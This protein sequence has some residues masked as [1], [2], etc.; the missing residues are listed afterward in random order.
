MRSGGGLQ[1]AKC[2]SHGYKHQY[3]TSMTTTMVT[4]PRMGARSH[5]CAQ[6]LR[7]ITHEHLTHANT[8]TRTH[9]TCEHMHTN[10]CAYPPTPPPPPP[11]TSPRQNVRCHL[12]PIMQEVRT[13]PGPTTTQ[14]SIITSDEKPVSTFPTVLMTALSPTCTCAPILTAFLS[15]VDAQTWYTQQKHDEKCGW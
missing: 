11:P 1:K 10:T 4:N 15:P 12:L 13:A 8:C 7:T 2:L 9:H 14:E 3:Q 6:T 5:T